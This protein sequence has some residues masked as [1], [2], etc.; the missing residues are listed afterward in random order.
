MMVTVI[1]LLNPL[2]PYRTRTGILNY[3]NFNQLHKYINHFLQL[4]WGLKFC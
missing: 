4:L 3:G 2:N 1:R